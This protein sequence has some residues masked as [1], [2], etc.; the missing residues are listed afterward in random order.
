MAGATV[1]ISGITHKMLKEL[2]NKMGRPMQLVLD[3][4]VEEYRRKCFFDELDKGFAALQADPK[5][6]EEELKER[7]LFE[8][9]LIDG[10]DDE[11]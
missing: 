6:W 5:A 10:Q 2:S 7:K 8:G 3:N 1:R 4:A 9:T 11:P